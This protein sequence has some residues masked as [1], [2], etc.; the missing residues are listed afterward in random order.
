MASS[1]TSDYCKIRR[2]TAVL[3]S[4]FLFSSSGA[5]CQARHQ[6]QKSTASSVKTG[7]VTSKD[8]IRLYYAKVG[9]GQNTVIMPG[10]LFAF[11][12]FQSLAKWRTLIFYDM[13]NRGRSDRVM[14]TS[15]I[16]L[17]HDADDLEAIRAH[18]GIEKPDLIGF[19]YLGKLV[20]PIRDATS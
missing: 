11:H 13:R 5:L 1:A 18:F 20:V 9:G 4:L 6:P 16:S 3:G 7:Y 17:Q 10:R 12:D 19:S 14:D 15:K 8:G 2:R